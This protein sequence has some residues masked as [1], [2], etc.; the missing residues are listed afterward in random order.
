MVED[1]GDLGI[2]YGY[3]RFRPDIMILV[4]LILVIMV[5]SFQ[6]VG[7]RLARRL[8]KRTLWGSGYLWFC[9]DER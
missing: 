5:Q 8:D 2:R 3:Q 4:V 1:L 6:T 7:E 9:S